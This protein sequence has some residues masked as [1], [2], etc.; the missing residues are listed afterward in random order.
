MFSSEVTGS[1]GYSA[2][3]GIVILIIFCVIVIVNIA[4]DREEPS[5]MLVAEVTLYEIPLLS[6]LMHSCLEL[7][8]SPLSP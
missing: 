5:F 6:N 4:C 2:P 7:I 1:A 3:S 8:S